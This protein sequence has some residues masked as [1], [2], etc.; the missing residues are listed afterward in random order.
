MSLTFEIKNPKAK[1]YIELL[2]RLGSLTEKYS[3]PEDIESEFKVLLLEVAR[4]QY[5]T[6]NRSGIAWARKKFAPETIQ[7]T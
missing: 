7:N 4:E 2:E 1:W 6:G 5:M 3:I